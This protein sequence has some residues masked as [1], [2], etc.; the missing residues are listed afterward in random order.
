[1]KLIEE[2]KTFAKRGN[3]LDMAVGIIIGAAFG[4]I[5]TS[6]VNDILMP[7]LGV[8][9]GGIDF[10]DLSFKLTTPVNSGKPVEILYGKFINTI[11]NF[12]IV[13]FSIFLVVKGMNRLMKKEGAKPAEPQ[14]PSEEVLLLTQIRDLLKK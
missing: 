1:M 12:I 3:V 11:V 4:S 6:L 13:A 8:L 7:P 5:V 10:T 14:K 2:F 9:I